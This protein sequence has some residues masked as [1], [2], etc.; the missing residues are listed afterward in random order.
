MIKIFNR[1]KVHAINSVCLCSSVKKWTQGTHLVLYIEMRWLSKHISLAR[2]FELMRATSEI[3]FKKTTTT[4]GRFQ[5]HRL[6]CKTC[7]LVWHIRPVRWTQSLQGRTAVF[8][9]ADEVAAL[10]VKLELWG[11]WVNI[12]IS[13][14]SRDFWKRLV[15]G[16]PSPRECM[17]TYLSFQEFEHYFQTQKTFELGRNESMTHLNPGE[18]T[19]FMLERDQLLEITNDGFLKC[20]LE[21]TL[22]LHMFWI[23]LKAEHPETAT[24]ALKSLVLFPASYICKA[25]FSPVTATKM[26]A[27]SGL[28][29]SR[30]LSVSLSILTPRGDC[31][32]VEKQAQG[33]HWPCIGMIV[34]SRFMS[35]NNNHRNSANN[36]C[37]VLESPWNLPPPLVCAKLPSTK[38]APGAKMFWTTELEDLLSVCILTAVLCC[39]KVGPMV[40]SDIELDTILANLIL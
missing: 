21:T 19:L 23:K 22:N 38:L 30:T 16:I 9:W 33:F 26:S 17:I 36:K 10:K 13:N 11:W 1:I 25:V 15:Q 3:S 24:K 6:G 2:D 37:H 27:W 29:W 34:S 28:D 12:G 5:W 31:L 39:Y 20:M 4:D 14:I 7:L 8:K 32:V 18:L 35:Q 40:W